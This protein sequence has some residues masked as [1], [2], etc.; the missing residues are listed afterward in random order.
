MQ[1]L[2]IEQVKIRSILT[3]EA[4][5]GVCQ[6]CYGR[7]MAS[8]FTVE[9]GEAVGV[10]AAQSIGEPGTQLTMRTFH[11]G[12]V[13]MGEKEQSKIEAKNDGTLRFHNVRAVE[14]QDGKLVVVNRSANIAV[15][16]YRGREVEHYQVPYGAKLLLPDGGEVKARRSVRR[17]GPV[18]H[19]H[20]DRGNGSRRLPRRRPEGDDGGIA[21]RD[22][23][24]D[25]PD[26]HR[27]QG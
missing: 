5:R 22:H 27:T 13:A 14:G 17:M 1:N 3:C 24:V 26:H 2:G 9:M 4:K 25:E 6:L 19:P 21:G 8:G 15:M 18:Q 7:N 20:P 23:R 11:I 10:V 12:G 16:D